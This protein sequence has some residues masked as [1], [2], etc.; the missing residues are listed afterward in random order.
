MWRVFTDT[1]IYYWKWQFNQ[2]KLPN[3]HH[4]CDWIWESAHIVHTS[5]FDYLE[6]YKNQ[7]KWYTELKV[8]GNIKEYLLNN[9]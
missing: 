7:C 6:F 4:I 3:L 5:D 1:V 2:Q 9:L 8:L